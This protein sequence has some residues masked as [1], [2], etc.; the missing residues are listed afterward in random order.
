MLTSQYFGGN[1]QGVQDVPTEGIDTHLKDN[2]GTLW[3]DI[4]K[5]DERD[6]EMLQAEFGFHPLALEDLKQRDQRPKVVEYDGYVFVVAHEWRPAPNREDLTCA[7]VERSAEIHAFVGK[8]YIVTVH[9]GDSEAL[10]TARKRWEANA[11]MQKQGP[12][13]LLYLLLDSLVDDYYPALDAYD[14]RIDTLERLVLQ[15]ISEQ[16]APKD[17]SRR[18]ARRRDA[19]ATKPLPTLLSLRRDLLE[20]RRYVAPLRDAVNVLLRYVESVE[21]DTRAEAQ[22]RERARALFAYY[23][24]VYDHT[25]RVVDTID[26]YRDLLSG[27]LDAHLAVASNRLNEIVKVLTSVSIILMTWAGITGLYGMNFTN[28]PELHWRYG[29]PYA[30]SLIVISGVAEWFYFRRRN[31]L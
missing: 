5:P 31:W 20:M 1:G 19:D 2:G 15:P 14:D 26:T 28:M 16:D 12:Y 30:L 6:F 4:S 7:C 18:A 27:T 13:F 8:N 10:K 21:D 24:D 23:Q 9:M 22:R 3:L 17:N 11:E 25:I 29:Y